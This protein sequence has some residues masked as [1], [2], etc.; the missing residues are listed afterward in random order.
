MFMLATYSLTPEM[1][2]GIFCLFGFGGGD[3]FKIGFLYVV[4]VAPSVDQASLELRDLLP[5]IKDVHHHYWTRNGI[6]ILIT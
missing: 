3:Y 5:L 4:L 2:F 6:F 1:S